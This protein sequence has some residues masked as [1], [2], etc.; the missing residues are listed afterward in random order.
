VPKCPTILTVAAL[1][2]ALLTLGCEAE[3]EEAPPAPAAPAAPQSPTAAAQSPGAQ[4][5]PAQSSPPTSSAEGSIFIVDG[6]TVTAPSD[7]QVISPRTD[8]DNPFFIP[9]V[10]EF[11]IMPPEGV[12]LPPAE[13]AA[14]ANIRG[15]VAF[16]ID[17]WEAQFGRDENA[18]LD[19]TTFNVNG[20]AVHHF[21]GKGT[22]SS[23]LPGSA[24]PIDQ[25]MVLG[26]VMERPDGRLVFIKATGARET[27]EPAREQWD[28]MVQS[29]QGPPNTPADDANRNEGTGASS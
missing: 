19:R 11:R 4:P 27:L 6:Y 26:V 16:N 3:Y 23:G 24:G 12:T 14:F 8:P 10:A 20:V 18:Q 17:R 15:G 9:R 7:W 28:A 25:M 5:S 2:S 13:V 1:S 21:V 22:F 29:I